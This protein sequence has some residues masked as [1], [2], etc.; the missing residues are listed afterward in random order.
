MKKSMSII[1]LGSALLLPNNNSVEA[2]YQNN[3]VNSYKDLKNV[4]YYVTYGEQ[5]FTYNGQEVNRYVNNY[6]N[7]F[8]KELG[9]KTQVKKLV[10]LNLGDYFKTVEQAK[11]ETPSKPVEQV[12]PETPSKPV[13]Q[14]KPETPSKPVEQ[15][16]PETPTPVEPS[17]QEPT[18]PE[19]EKPS[20]NTVDTSVS[21]IE[22]AVLDLTNAERQKAGLQP[23]QADTKLMNSARQKSADMAANNYFSHTSPTYG[24]PFDQMKSNGISYRSAA[25][26]IA[27]GQRS[28]EEV[29]KAWME[30]PGHRQ[31][32]LTAEFT[33]IGIGY[34]ANGK[35]W[36][37]QFIQK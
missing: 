30:S 16:K 10:K 1:L 32:I 18:Q 4:E 7:L 11:P 20:T 14:A 34:D 33:H 17:T 13:E 31:N 26:N 8:G 15:A 35:Y 5:S 28:A 2:S 36:T 25:E 27:M 29:V 22:K 19:V 3:E 6:E 24:S 9:F 12:K 37:Q 21:A 23:L